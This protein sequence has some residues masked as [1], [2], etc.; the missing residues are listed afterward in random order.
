MAHFTIPVWWWIMMSVE[1]SVECLAEETEILGEN[2]PQCRFVHHKSHMAQPGLQL[3]PLWWESWALLAVVYVTCYVD[4]SLTS[5]VKVLSPWQSERA[6][7]LWHRSHRQG[8]EQQGRISQLNT[9]F[10]LDTLHHIDRFMVDTF[11]VSTDLWSVPCIIS[12][13]L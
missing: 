11:V 2:L 12:T 5:P 3:A 7:C 6:I 13:D 4:S 10:M 8:H 1:Q 9:W